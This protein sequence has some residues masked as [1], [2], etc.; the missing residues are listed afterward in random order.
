MISRVRHSGQHSDKGEQ[1]FRE[2]RGFP[3]HS[4]GRH[5]MSCRPSSGIGQER[6]QHLIVSSRVSDA[7]P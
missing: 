6:G 3:V 2:W 7:T 4:D 5:Q 1:R